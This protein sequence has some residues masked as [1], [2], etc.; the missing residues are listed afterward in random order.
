V[1]VLIMLS[2]GR[3]GQENEEFKVIFAYKTPCLNQKQSVCVC[4][5]VKHILNRHQNNIY[6]PS[7]A[8]NFSTDVLHFNF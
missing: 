8:N 2:F 3:W 7:H 4:V 6:E 5:C 1:H